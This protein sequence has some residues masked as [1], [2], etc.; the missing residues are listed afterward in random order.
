MQRSEA[1]APED[2]FRAVAARH[3]D[4]L[5]P[6]PKRGF[7]SGALKVNGKIFASLTKGR[8]LLKL[9]EAVVD[10][11]IAAKK[12]ERFSTGANRPTKEWITIEVS[13]AA[14]WIALSEQARAY[15]QSGQI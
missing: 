1:M 7:G 11:L 10:S 13:D 12:G 14:T 6:E 4:A 8:L 2:L 5:Q 15:V 3:A 9:P